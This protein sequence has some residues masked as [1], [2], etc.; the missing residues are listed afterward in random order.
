MDGGQFWTLLAVLASSVVFSTVFCPDPV[1]LFLYYSLLTG[2]RLVDGIVQVTSKGGALALASSEARLYGQMKEAQKRGESSLQCAE[3]DQLKVIGFN[4]MVRT[5]TTYTMHIYSHQRCDYLSHTHTQAKIYTHNAYIFTTLDGLSHTHTYRP[6]LH[7]SSAMRSGRSHCS[8]TWAQRGWCKKLM[9]HLFYCFTVTVRKSG[10]LSGQSRWPRGVRNRR[11]AR[12]YV[13][14]S[15]I[16][17]ARL[18][19]CCGC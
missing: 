5:C 10:G 12:G 16:A 11:S 6:R 14:W 1:F 9:L 13:R 18:G 17:R 2:P 8:G 7:L 19:M 3:G 4:D 15:R